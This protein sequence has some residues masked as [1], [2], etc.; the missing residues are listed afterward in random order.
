MITF[1]DL[2]AC[3]RLI[4]QLINE[5][6][7]THAESKNWRDYLIRSIGDEEEIVIQP[8]YNDV[9]HNIEDYIQIATACGCH[10]YVDIQENQEGKLTP[11]LKIF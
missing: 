11:T 5:E 6:I 7:E 3:E 4:N 1:K 2:K 9:F 10:L 8:T